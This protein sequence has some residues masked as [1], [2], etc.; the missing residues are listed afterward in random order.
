M[1]TALVILAAGESSRLGECKALARIGPRTAIEHLLRESAGLFDGR[2]LVVTGIHH[3]AIDALLSAQ[4]E[5]LFHAGWRL[6]RTGGIALA[7]TARREQALCLAPVDCPLVPRAVFAALLDAWARALRPERGW[8]A[9]RHALRDGHPVLVGP[10]L[11]LG[12]E[13]LGSATSL[14]EL[15]GGARP[16]LSLEVDCPAIHDDLDTPA[17]LARLR[18][19]LLEAGFSH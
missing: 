10:G 5:C 12:I 19:R 11:A 17:D 3:A 15:R 13:D 18:Q 8:L 14:R 6:G 2:T 9:P 4:V 16:Q 7:R 1:K